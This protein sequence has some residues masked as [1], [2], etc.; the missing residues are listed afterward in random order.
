M[1]NPQS[2]YELVNYG[3]ESRAMLALPPKDVEFMANVYWT[4]KISADID[5][6][7]QNIERKKSRLEPLTVDRTYAELNRSMTQ[8][9]GIDASSFLR[10]HN[11]IRRKSTCP[12]N[13]SIQYPGREREYAGEGH[14]V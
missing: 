1:N 13:Y 7:K 6:E 8:A 9:F 12:I 14:L 3:L 2:K 10:T 11:A 4:L 5:V